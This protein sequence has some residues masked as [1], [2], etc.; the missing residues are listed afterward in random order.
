MN[1]MS[2]HGR[3][4]D[5][6][7]RCPDFTNVQDVRRILICHDTSISG[8]GALRCGLELA[9]HFGAAVH[10]L[11]CFSALQSPAMLTSALAGHYCCALDLEAEHRE[12]LSR[13]LA[14]LGTKGVSALGHLAQGDQWEDM[15]LLCRQFSID[16]VVV[17]RLPM[18]PRGR[19]WLGKRRRLLAD[20]LNCGVFVADE[21]SFRWP[22]TGEERS[23]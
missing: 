23:Q 3:V 21:N 13:A 18:V 16:L 10:V 6:R 12:Q 15:V 20:Q 4:P 7:A 14:W 11:S 9:Q 22:S 1:D 5:V 2:E 8:I 19:W 17:G